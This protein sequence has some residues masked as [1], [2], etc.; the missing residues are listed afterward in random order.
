MPHHIRHGGS[1]IGGIQVIKKTTGQKK[2]G[3]YRKESDLTS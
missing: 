3:G 1:F 2:Y